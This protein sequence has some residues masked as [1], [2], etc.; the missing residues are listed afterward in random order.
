MT[1]RAGITAWSPTAAS[2]WQNLGGLTPAVQYVLGRPADSTLAVAQCTAT[3]LAAKTALLGIGVDGTVSPAAAST[4]GG[5]TGA[6]SFPLTAYA[7]V[8]GVIGARS[9]TPI[10]WSDDTGTVYRGNAQELPGL[11]ADILC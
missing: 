4:S 11:V 8:T 1:W 10:A 3:P 5:C 9:L 7:E 2:T 6:A